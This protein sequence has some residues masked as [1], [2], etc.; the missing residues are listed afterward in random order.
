[1][2][3]GG[4]RGQESRMSGRDFKVPF[5][6]PVAKTLAASFYSCALQEC[7]RNN[8]GGGGCRTSALPLKVQLCWAVQEFYRKNSG[9]KK[10]QRHYLLRYNSAKIPGVVH[11]H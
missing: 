10:E 1:M 5:D 9:G 2:K 3:G 4:G 11:V 8:S 6:R 7:N